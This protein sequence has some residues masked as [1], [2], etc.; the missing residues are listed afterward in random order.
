MRVAAVPSGARMKIVENVVDGVG[1]AQMCVAQLPA[2]LVEQLRFL[3]GLRHA[4]LNTGVGQCAAQVEKIFTLVLAVVEC[5]VCARAALCE[6]K[7]VQV[8]AG[9]C[10]CARMCVRTAR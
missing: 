7:C 10:A 9:V 8:H 5:C 4:E 1:T 6:W 2:H 3:L